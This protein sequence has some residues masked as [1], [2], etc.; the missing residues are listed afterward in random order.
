MSWN[1]WIA[2]GAAV[3][4][5]VLI[6]VRTTRGKGGDTSGTGPQ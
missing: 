4:L 1:Y 5:V 6:V 2:I 3:V